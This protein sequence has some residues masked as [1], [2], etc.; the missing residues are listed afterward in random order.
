M[1]VKLIVLDIGGGTLTAP[2]WASAQFALSTVLWTWIIVPLVYYANSFGA[3]TKLNGGNTLN[4]PHL[5][6]RNYT[7]VIPLDLMDP[8]TYNLNQT[9]YDEVQP[10]YITT[11]FASKI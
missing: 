6:G 9:A 10:I 1:I 3:D 8:L 2:F 5:F 4:T 7:R 11:M